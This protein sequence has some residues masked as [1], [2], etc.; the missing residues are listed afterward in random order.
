[1]MKVLIV[2]NG[3]HYKKKLAKLLAEHSITWVDQ[4]DAELSLLDQGFNL[5]VLSGAYG[6][7]SVKH[8]SNKL[9]SH[10]QELIRKASVPVIGLCYAAQL[11]AHMY[12][13]HLS[14]VPGGKRIRGL[15]RIW[16]IKQTPFDFFDY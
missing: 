7:H 13:A 3:T 11:I 4:K 1:M 9:L 2:D 15:K 5:I 14:F 16:N 10:E 6:T 8:Y 12:G